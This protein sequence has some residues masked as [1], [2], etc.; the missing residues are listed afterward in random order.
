MHSKV[1]WLHQFTN[2]ARLGI[3]ARP[4]GNDWLDQEITQLKKQGTGVMVSLLE[5]HEVAEL[6]LSKQKDICIAHGIEYINFPI[7]DRSIPAAGGK[8]KDLIESLTGQIN[9]GNSVVIHCRMGIGR[10]SIIAGSILLKIGYKPNEVLT[11]IS[12]IRGLKVP[13][14]EEQEKWLKNWHYK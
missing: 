1:Y 7:V 12:K 11:H 2:A 8:I 13:D 14:T 10:S 3:M 6:G 5:S 4:R 9:Q